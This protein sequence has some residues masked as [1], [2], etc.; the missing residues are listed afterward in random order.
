MEEPIGS[1]IALKTIM[2]RRFVPRHYHRELHQRLQSLR[3]GTRSVEDFYK[4][5]E[6]L[7]NRAD[8]DEDREATMARFIGGL[9]K[10]IADRVELQH[11]V[12]LEELVHLA[13]KVEKQLKPKGTARFEYK[14]TS[15]G[16][17]HWSSSWKGGKKGDD[18]VIPNNNKGKSISGNKDTSKPEINKEK[19]R[20]IKC[21][22]CLGRGHIASQCPNKRAMVARDHGEIETASEESDNDDEIPQL[23]DGSDDCIEGPTGGELLVARR[24]LSVQMKEDDTLEQQRDNI[25]HTRCHV[26]GKTCLVI[27]NGGSCTNVASTLM[28]EKLGLNLIPHPRPYKLLWLN[29]CGE[30][31]VN[32]QVVVP[33]TIGRYSDEAL[34]DV[35]PMHAGHILLGRPWEFDTGAFHDGFLNRYS[36][37]KDGRKVTLTPLSPKEVYDDQCKLERERQ[38]T[39]AK[40]S[41]LA[42]ESEVRHAFH[43]SRMLFVVTYKD[44]YLN[45]TELDLS[46]PSVF[47]NLLQEFADVFPEEMPSGL[48]PQR[49]IEHQ[50]DFI[51][52]A[53][54]PNRPAYRSNPEETKELQRQKD[55]TWRMC[56][57]CRA[58]NKITVKYRHPIPRLDDMLDELHGACLFTKIDLRS[59]YYQICMKTG[60]EWKTA[61]KTKYGLYEWLVMPFGLTNAPST[62]MRL[63][64]HVLHECLGKFVVVYFDDILVYSKSIDDHV[65]HVR[66]I[67]DILRVEKLYAN[68]KKCA[69]CMD[70]VNFLGFVVS[71]K[72][73]EVDVE[74]VKAIREWPTPKNIS[75]VRSFHGLASFYR[76]FIKDFSSIAA[77]LNEI[78]KK[79]VGF[80]WGDAQEH[81]FNM[82]KDKLCIECDA[83]GIGIGAVLMQE[84]RP[85]CYFSEKLNGAALRY[86]TYDKELYALVRALQ[87]WQ[88]YLWP[89]EFVI[90]TDHESLKHLKG[91]DKL[92]RRHAKWME[93]IET[94]PYVIKYKKGKE[95]V[96]ADALSRRYALLTTL[97]SKLLGFEFIKELYVSDNDF[98]GMFTTCANGAVSADFYVFEGFLFKK[99]RLCIPNCSLRAVL[100]R[101]AHGGG[102]MGHFGVQKTYD[103]LIEH[104]YWPCMKRDV[105]KICGQ[106]IVCLKAKSKLQPHGLYTPL[107]IPDVPWTNLSMDFVLGLPRSRKGRDSIF[108]VV[109]STTHTSPFEIVYGFNPLTP[110]DLIP[111]PLNKLVSVEGSSKADLV[112]KLHKQVQERIEKQNAKVAERVNKG[113]IPMV[114]QPG[115]WVWVHFHKER[116]PNQRK[117]KLSP[118]G[119]GPFQVLERINDN[120]YKIDLKG[121]ELD[122]R[123]NHPKEGGNKIHILVRALKVQV[124]DYSGRSVADT[125][126]AT[127]HHRMVSE[128]SRPCNKS[129]D[130]VVSSGDA[131]F[132]FTDS[133]LTPTIVQ[134][135][136]QLPR[137]E[138]EKLIPSVWITNYEKLH[139]SSQPVQ[140]QDPIFIKQLDKCDL[141]CN[142]QDDLDDLEIGSKGTKT[143]K[144]KHT[145][146]S[147]PR[148]DDKDDDQ[149]DSIQVP[150]K[151]KKERPWIGLPPEKNK[152]MSNDDYLKRCFEILKEGL[153]NCPPPPMVCSCSFEPVKIPESV[154]VPCFMVNSEEFPPLA[155]KENEQTKAP[156]R[157][158]IVKDTVQPA[159]SLA[160][161]LAAEEVLNWQTN[162]AVAQNHYLEKI[163]NRLSEVYEKTSSIEAH[164]TS[165]REEAL[166]MHTKLSSRL[167]KLEQEME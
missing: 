104:F 34:C 46:L 5:M 99:N 12:E 74:K 35:V 49:G 9:N 10:E 73:L 57:D 164:V 88:H 51:P 105:H 43:S 127:L 31:K 39:K 25:F 62:F 87:T 158:F 143:W 155:R 90:H 29:N 139:Q 113:R 53:S 36:F 103:I 38:K 102:L 126:S 83:S 130:P 82:L 110:I 123:T 137:E 114:F 111:L 120:A 98:S 20:D 148:Y 37:V 63:M 121:D 133:G 58:I 60:D 80:T 136:R 142:C 91:Q 3:Q 96:V 145:C 144:R 59:G 48:P 94:F 26:Q 8:L 77:P 52:G 97:D 21:F 150:A 131:L 76:R 141:G 22:K 7:M 18:K 15:S 61:F 134:T 85:I 159:G 41:F 55:G 101:E 100:V 151:N 167:F 160:P 147:P 161:L 117:S 42:R 152:P 162:N 27:I 132:I 124:Q 45:T 69:F 17:P 86:P 118:R 108:V 112:K 122:P 106:C 128:A 65:M 109:D 149:P 157:P 28:V 70:K 119:D 153:L 71:S 33:F 107:P 129:A 138:L 1:W 11:Y 165:F 30:I 140:K 56:V 89:K 6:M 93:F 72:G 64:N 50:I 116:V 47:A 135:P 54:I 14:G 23:E 146:S 79:N 2:R 13:I 44:V 68:L 92:N 40:G 81:A 163:D 32:K 66:R 24:T 75:Q 156:A 16:R 154:A 166:R 84:G 115:D 95:N 125:I 78:V 4:E 19:N 67:L